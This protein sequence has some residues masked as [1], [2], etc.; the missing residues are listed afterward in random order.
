[1]VPDIRT[2]TFS[3][4]FFPITRLAIRTNSFICAFLYG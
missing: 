1:M 2:S 4:P 3:K